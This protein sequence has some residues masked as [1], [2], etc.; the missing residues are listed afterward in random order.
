MHPPSIL[1]LGGARPHAVSAAVNLGDQA[2][3][4]E[5]VARLQALMPEARLVCVANS[6]RERAEGDTPPL[7]HTVIAYLAGRRNE[8]VRLIP[9]PV[10]RLIRCALL[11]LNARR[12]TAGRPAILLSDLGRSALRELQAADA[13]F[14]SGAGAFNDFYATSVGGLWCLLIRIMSTLRKPVVASGQ[15]V[16]PLSHFLPRLIVRWGLRTIDALGVREPKSFE[17]AVGLGVPEER[18]VLTGDDAWDL[19]PAP[20]DVARSILVRHGIDGPF[21]AAQVRFGS[22]TGWR[23]EDA[24]H[25]GAAL[26]RLGEDFG[27]PVVFV[28]LSHSRIGNEEQDAAECVSKHMRERP[29]VVAEHLDAPTTKAVLGEAFLGVGISYHFCVFAASMGT[30]VIGM[31]SSPYMRHKMQGLAALELQQV[32]A[33]PREQAL[34]RES[35]LHV[36]HEL[37]DRHTRHDA[38]PDAFE[39]SPT[40]DEAIHRLRAFLETTRR[41][42]PTRAEGAELGSRNSWR[43]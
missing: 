36:V 26:S 16:G 37:L 19:Q 39:V 15:Q 9:A 41:Q 31:H 17:C 12:I 2:Q 23:S 11:L 24:P 18:I 32:V 29:A 1:V 20:A 40:R 14:L 10:A 21:I 5:G 8:S 3:L 35:L 34:R 28:L 42:V 22:S 13:L 4:L 25:L 30:P 27:L 6:L 38:E 33:L 43:W 7:S